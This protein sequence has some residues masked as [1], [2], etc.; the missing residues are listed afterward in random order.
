MGSGGIVAVSV[1]PIVGVGV[2]EGVG[3]GGI[4][5][6]GGEVALGGDVDK[7]KRDATVSTGVGGAPSIGAGR[8]HAPAVSDKAKRRPGPAT[9]LME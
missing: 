6:V 4:V 8:V 3:V 5:A 9:R 7:G 1:G 2:D